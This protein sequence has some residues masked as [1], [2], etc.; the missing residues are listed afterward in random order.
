MRYHHGN[1][2]VLVFFVVNVVPFGNLNLNINNSTK[3]VKN[4]FPQFN[5]KNT[6]KLS[7]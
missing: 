7:V 5:H 6:C 4:T 3:A 2:E 1:A